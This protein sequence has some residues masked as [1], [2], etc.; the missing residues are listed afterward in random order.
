MKKSKARSKQNIDFAKSQ[1]RMA[2]DYVLIVWQWV[3]DRQVLGQKFRREH[4][5]PPYTVDFFC[6]EL[7][8]VIEIDGQPH[9]TPEGIAHDRIRDRF[10]KSLGYKILR[11][12]GYEIL[13]DSNAAR[14]RIVGFVE[15][16]L[17]DRKKVD[18]HSAMRGGLNS[19]TR[20]IPPHPPRPFSPVKALGRRGARR[21]FAIAN[22]PASKHGGEGGP[23][24][25][26][27][28]LSKKNQE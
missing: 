22:S 27:E 8:L 10:L 20:G 15:F 26:G 14:D 11:I 13:R 16:A 2:S 21:F 9:L 18:G 23:S 12:P 19:L 25:W 28:A 24:G 5:V 7:G 3:R 17:E 4:P 6:V 1:R